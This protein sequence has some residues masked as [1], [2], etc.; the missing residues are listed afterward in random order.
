MYQN[1]KNKD[2]DWSYASY[3]YVTKTSFDDEFGA[4]IFYV[5]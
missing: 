5:A 1:L 3:P 4:T 2:R